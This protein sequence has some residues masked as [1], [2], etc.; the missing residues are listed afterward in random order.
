MSENAIVKIRR[1]DPDVSKESRFDTFEVPPESYKGLKVVEALRYIYE[2]LD[3]SLA[4]RETCGQRMCGGCMIMVN[5]KN[6]L[7]CDALAEK[8]MTIEPASNRK[9]LRDLIVDLSIDEGGAGDSI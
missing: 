2:N 6:V 8:E 5:S 3:H 9:V 4:F 1:Y 7:A